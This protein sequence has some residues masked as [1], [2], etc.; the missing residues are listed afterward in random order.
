MN[1][2]SGLQRQVIYI[3]PWCYTCW[4]IF[5]YVLFRYRLNVQL[6]VQYCVLIIS[7]PPSG[8]SGLKPLLRV[9]QWSLIKQVC[10]LGPA[11]SELE[12]CGYSLWMNFLPPICEGWWKVMFSLCSFVHH[13][14]G[15]PPSYQLRRGTPIQLTGGTP[16]QLIWGGGRGTPIWTG[17]GGGTP[18]PS[19]LYGLSPSLQE[20]EHHIEHLLHGG[21]YA[22]CVYASGL[23]C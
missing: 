12:N 21:R 16:I 17:W 18:P 5:H 23:S 6:L 3:C 4:T 15:V 9:H 10:R 14:E 1:S 2:T 19:Q 7:I 20:T 8:L 13:G 11:Y 22:S